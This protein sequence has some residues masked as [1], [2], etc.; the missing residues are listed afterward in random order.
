MEEEE[1]LETKLNEM[2]LVLEDLEQKFEAK[3]FEL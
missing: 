2:Q 3:D 1:V